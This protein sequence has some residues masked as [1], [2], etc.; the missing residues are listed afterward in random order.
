MSPLVGWCFATLLA[1][2][3]AFAP[4]AVHTSPAARLESG[5]ISHIRMDG[6]A[7]AVAEATEP[8]KQRIANMLPPLQLFAP[9]ALWFAYRHLGTAAFA[10][11]GRIASLFACLTILVRGLLDHNFYLP[12]GQSRGSPVSWAHRKV[13]RAFSKLI[14]TTITASILKENHWRPLLPQ[15]NA[16]PRIGAAD[17][18][19]AGS[20]ANTVLNAAHAELNQWK[21]IDAAAELHPRVAACMEDALSGDESKEATDAKAAMIDDL[22]SAALPHI[23]IPG[24]PP[25]TLD[26]CYIF[27]CAQ[28]RG[29]Y[30]PHVHWDTEYM[31][32]P[33][34]EAFQLWYLIEN[35]ETTGNM[36]MAATD[37]LTPTDA[38][39]RYVLQADGSVLKVNHDA[40]DE[41]CPIKRFAKAEDAGLS[42][43]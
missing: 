33:E 9:V 35:D 16:A 32:F 41:E 31:A 30:F 14:M 12:R 7:A 10:W 23:S 2:A 29:A 20:R 40:T 6:A 37:D 34:V 38:P 22:V 4:P 15:L 18:H 39:C 8:P 24:R 17:Y 19:A 43:E 26:D 28:E 11:I 42:F 13:K 27:S 3:A 25:L 1:S 36:F 5:H 21:I